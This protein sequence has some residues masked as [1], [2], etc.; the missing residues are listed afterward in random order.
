MIIYHGSNVVVE[1][2]KI[3]QS[4]RMLDFGT[5]FYT[6][7]N[8]EQAVRWSEIVCERREPKIPV[9]SVYEFDFE[10]AKRELVIIRFDEPSDEWFDFVCN[11]RS[12]R[13]DETQYDIVI[14]PVANDRVY[15]VVQYYENGVYGKEEAIKR[16]K[17]DALYNQILFHTEKSLTFCRFSKSIEVGS[18]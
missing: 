1:Q 4:E 11:N 12:G 5:G 13:D 7:S 6:T 8:K 17:V 2:P 16:L 3:L 10:A 15:A 18:K 9:L 14:G